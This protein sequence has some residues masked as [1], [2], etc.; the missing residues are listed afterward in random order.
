MGEGSHSLKFGGESGVFEQLLQPNYPPAFRL[1]RDV[2]TMQP[3]KVSGTGTAG[4]RKATVCNVLTGFA[5]GGQLTL[6]R[7]WRTSR[8]K[9]PSRTGRLEVTPG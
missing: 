7:R 3:D 1:L 5:A 4:Q 2:T 9:L 6:S 8:R